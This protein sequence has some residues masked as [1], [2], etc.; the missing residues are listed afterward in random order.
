ML[1]KCLLR[2]YSVLLQLLFLQYLFS[3]YPVPLF[4][5]STQCLC[6]AYAVFMQYLFITRAVPIQCLFSAYSVLIQRLCSAYAVPM[7]WGVNA[8]S[9]VSSAHSVLLCAYSVLCQ[10]PVRALSAYF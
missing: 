1:I 9:V 8:Y 5:A 4:S 10:C 6:S 3:A 2:S 7:Q